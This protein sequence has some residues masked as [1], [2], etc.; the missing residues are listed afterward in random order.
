MTDDVTDASQKPPRAKPDTFRTIKALDP[1]TEQN[2]RDSIEAI[3]QGQMFKEKQ[4]IGILMLDNERI[5]SVRDTLLPKHFFD[6]R[7]GKLYHAILEAYEKSKGMASIDHVSF[8]REILDAG[9]SPKEIMDALDQV[10]S[11]GSVTLLD[12]S[13]RRFYTE[14]M[15]FE[16]GG[17]IRQSLFA[18]DSKDSK[19]PEEIA[20][21][22]KR[23]ID[24]LP[25]SHEVQVSESEAIVDDYVARYED[26]TERAFNVGLLMEGLLEIRDNTLFVLAATPGSGKSAFAI[27]L[28]IEASGQIPQEESIPVFYSFEMSRDQIVSRFLAAKSPMTYGTID[29]FQKKDPLV[30]PLIKQTVPL[31]P[32]FQL[33]ESAGWTVEMVRSSVKQLVDKGIKPRPIVID[34]LQI[35]KTHNDRASEYEKVTRAV[36]QLK[37]LA[38]EF[39]TSVVCLSQLS[40]EAPKEGKPKLHHLRGS[41]AIEQDADQV[42]FLNTEN[43]LNESRELS[44]TVAKNRQ[45]PIFDR[46]IIF[47]PARNI[48]AAPRI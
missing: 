18:K 46:S 14:K 23:W 6:A 33:F 44:F 22:I 31:L 37:S 25:Y 4:L 28:I 30:L 38:M 26:K 39:H 19:A 29:R 34:Y 40:R 20:E 32:K 5:L 47:Y 15:L 17:R 9:V 13:I 24:Q 41:G 43:S 11:L 36:G 12:Q 48:F 7:L 42:V 27:H 3:A 16:L 8:N 1:L 10:I 21:L 35:I 2:A 45:G